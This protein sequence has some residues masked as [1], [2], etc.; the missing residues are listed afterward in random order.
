MKAIFATLGALLAA[1]AAAQRTAPEPPAMGAL[2]LHP[3]YLTK[4]GAAFVDKPTLI[5]SGDTVEGWGYNVYPSAVEIVPGHKT[6]AHWTRFSM[7]CSAK[8]A[9]VTWVI[10]RVLARTTFTA[11]VDIK[12]PIADGTGWDQ[13]YAYICDKVPIFKE[14]GYT[15]EGI[16][17]SQ[18]WIE[19]SRIP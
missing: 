15:N 8:T 10:G 9:T 7:S 17:T 4:T 12:I 16:A 18:A 5:R 13:T 6:D 1:P 11:P 2:E 3:V 14:G 19:M